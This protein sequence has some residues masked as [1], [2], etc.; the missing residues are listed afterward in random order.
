MHFNRLTDQLIFKVMDKELI[1]KLYDVTYSKRLEVQEVESLKD[2]GE[3]NPIID[4][5]I[6][7]YSKLFTK[8]QTKAM[9]S[10][11]NSLEIEMKLNKKN[12]L[13]TKIF[14]GSYDSKNNR[15]VINYYE[16]KSIPFDLEKT[17]IHELL[18]MSSTRE[19]EKGLITGLEIP[20]LLGENFNEAYTDYLTNKYFT[21]NDREISDDMYV[22]IKGIEMLVGKEKLRECYSEAN[23]G[24]LINEMEP[25]LNKKDLLKLFYLIDRI[26]DPLFSYKDFRTVLREI[27]KMN[28]IRINN[29]FEEG[30]ITSDEYDIEFARITEF[31]VCNIWNEDAEVVRD[32]D[33]FIFREE[34]RTS[35]VY[36][37]NK[38]K[39]K[40]PQFEKKH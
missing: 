12:L 1:E 32:D 13:A 37:F 4:K 33:S 7:I 30:K 39:E 10:R 38:N 40:H 28:I 5:F 11:L 35:E 21:D 25:Y 14:L 26:D 17:L 8:E 29:L 23:I 31:R 16:D 18:H 22:A 9:L 6:S 19:T 3:F 2:F 24:K 20:G 27:T 36:L 15:I 34:D